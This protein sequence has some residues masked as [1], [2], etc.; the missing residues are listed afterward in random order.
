MVGSGL[1]TTPVG[2]VPAGNRST[3]AIRALKLPTAIGEDK[4]MSKN[5]PKNIV[6]FHSIPSNTYRDEAKRI[7][8]Y[9]GWYLGHSRRERG[10]TRAAAAQLAGMKSHTI[11]QIEQGRGPMDWHVMA[12]LALVMGVSLAD[13]LWEGE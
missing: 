8:R 6:P 13:H 5:T 4:G 12:K 3:R 10:L 1:N 11:R 7:R 9:M 2:L